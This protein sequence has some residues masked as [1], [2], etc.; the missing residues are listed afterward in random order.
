LGSKAGARKPLAIDPDYTSISDRARPY[1]TILERAMI[2]QRRVQLGM[3]ICAARNICRLYESRRPANLNGRC[4][5]VD[6]AVILLC[7]HSLQILSIIFYVKGPLAY[8]GGK[9]KIANKIIEIFPPHVTYVETFAGGA[10]TLFHKEPSKVEILNDLDSDVVTFFRVCQ[11]HHDELVRY[12]KFVVISRE[13]FDRLQAQDP[14]SLTDIQ[15]AARF[16]YLQKNAYA[17]L[18][19]KRKLGYSVTEPTR[20]N[21]ESIPELIENTHKRLARV[22]IEHLPYEQILGRYDRP[23]TLFYLDPPYFGRKLYNFN[24]SESD[25]VELSTRIG[26]LRGK[27]VL[28]L[29]DVPEVR[30]IF[31]RFHFREIDLAYTAQQTAGKRFRELLITNYRP[32]HADSGGT[33]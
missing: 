25:F 29:N 17:G 20:F 27:F 18:I 30:R 32:G 28:S 14:Q 9:S 8:I 19:R 22:Q 4:G 3:F 12:L 33:R 26:E 24:F 2:G 21:P 15:R 11:L 6:T 23:R 1:P 7:A 10:Q 13:W 5:S 16:F 31:R